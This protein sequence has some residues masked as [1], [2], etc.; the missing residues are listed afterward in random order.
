MDRADKNEVFRK[1]SEALLVDYS[2]VYYVNAVTNE[3]YWYST[4]PKFHSLRLA[5]SG[6]DFF[7]NLKRDCKKVIYEEDQYIFLNDMK[8]ENLLGAMAKGSMQSVEYR[9]LIDGIPTWHA[10]K[11][12]VWLPSMTLSIMSI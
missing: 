12:R 6:D 7:E 10:L 5:Q 1:I 9:L 3:Y 4:D 8:K 2:S 11:L